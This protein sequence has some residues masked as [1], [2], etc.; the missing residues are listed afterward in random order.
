MQGPT[1]AND[2]L[3]RFQTPLY[4]TSAGAFLHGARP[5]RCHS[6]ALSSCRHTNLALLELTSTEQLGM[7]I[8]SPTVR[9]LSFLS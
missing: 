5:Q 6:Y 3:L 2:L 7:P 1:D 4:E 8:I 9:T